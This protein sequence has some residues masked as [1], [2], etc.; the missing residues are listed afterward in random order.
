MLLGGP[1]GQKALLSLRF[2]GDLVKF[3]KMRDATKL[4]IVIFGGRFWLDLGAPCGHDTLDS[5]Q[6]TGKRKQTELYGN[7][8]HKMLWNLQNIHATMG[9]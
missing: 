8:K 2:K 5:F 3:A 1:R 7:N 4:E 9:F 6:K